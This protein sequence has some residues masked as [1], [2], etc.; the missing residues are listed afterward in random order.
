MYTKFIVADAFQIK[1]C[2]YILIFHFKL[3]VWTNI[4]SEILKVCSSNIK[5]SNCEDSNSVSDTYQNL[6]ISITNEI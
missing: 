6:Q 1:N 5:L 3:N 2:F 4:T